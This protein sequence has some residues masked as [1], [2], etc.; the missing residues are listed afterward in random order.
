MSDD[1]REFFRQRQIWAPL[2]GAGVMLL[3]YAIAFVLPIN[4]DVL[5][6]GVTCGLAF[7]VVEMTR[8]G[9]RTI[10]DFVQQQRRREDEEWNRAVNAGIANAD[11]L[12]GSN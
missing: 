9:W 8:T 12:R 3:G 7:F 5:V 10:D 2:Q 4:V 6:F 1:L 11:S